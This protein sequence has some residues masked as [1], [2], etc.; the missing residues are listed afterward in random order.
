MFARH[1]GGVLGDCIE[2]AVNRDLAVVV[3]GTLCVEP[4]LAVDPK[5]LGYGVLLVI[6]VDLE[7]GSG[8]ASAL[9]GE[10]PA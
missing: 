4:F 1:R 8:P 7:E 5:F 3:I 6:R 10:S 2:Q 9:S